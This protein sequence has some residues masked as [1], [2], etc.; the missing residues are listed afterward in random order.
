MEL[1]YRIQELLD[2]AVVDIFLKVQEEYNIPCGDTDFAD[3]YDLC[4][5]Q[6]QI[7]DKMTAMLRKQM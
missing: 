7:A 3:E 2:D 1:N 5:L 4:K 6:E